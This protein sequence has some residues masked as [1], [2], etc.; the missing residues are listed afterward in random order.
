MPCHER[1]SAPLVGAEGAHQRPLEE[2]PKPTNSCHGT[3][4]K[5]IAFDATP[6][7]SKPAPL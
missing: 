5:M 6:S 2:A 4:Q 7:P 1:H 3:S